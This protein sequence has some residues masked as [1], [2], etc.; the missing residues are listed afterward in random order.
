MILGIY[1]DS[2]GNHGGVHQYSLALLNALKTFPKD[3]YNVVAICATKE[4]YD[5]C[6]RNEVE[7]YYTEAVIAKENVFQ[8]I[9]AF[10]KVLIK[11]V[12]I[13]EVKQRKINCVFFPSVSPNMIL[14]KS[15]ICAIHDLMH[16]YEHKYPEVSSLY[17]YIL[18]DILFRIIANKSLV[19]LVD[20]ELSKLQVQEC[21]LHGK[22]DERIV[23][24][25]FIAPD[26][27]YTINGS[28][29]K[30]ELDE[31]IE[32]SS[33]IPKKYFFYPAQFWKHKN[34]IALLRGI[35]IAKREYPDIHIV[36]VGSKKNAYD[37]ILR[38]IREHN[39]KD[40]ITIL[41]YVS[42]YSMV[43]L[44]KNAQALFMASCFGPTNIPQLEAFYLGCPVAVA[45][46]YAV[47]EQV[48]DAA[49]LFEP[50]DYKQIAIYMKR[51]WVDETLKRKLCEKGYQRAVSWGPNQFAARLLS[52]IDNVWR[53]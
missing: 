35:E 13:L 36:F 2:K 23:P 39:L 24:L 49:L 20:S 9:G 45:D 15:S 28:F 38:F 44:Y 17:Q 5:F 47:R 10:L 18:R 40:N 30:R 50:N 11:G 43:Q 46:V 6:K 32:T 48:K 22:C 52:I 4:W 37:S 21:Y 51:L 29:E 25:P 16:R 26:Y 53:H 12:D 27:I 8:F 7:C 31:W 42:N 19:V 34:H 41:G 3:K 1:L 33:K 14:V